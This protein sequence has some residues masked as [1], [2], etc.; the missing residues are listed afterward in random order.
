MPPEVLEKLVARVPAG[1]AAEVAEIARVVA[2]VASPRASYVTGQTL[3]VCGG[4][5]LAQ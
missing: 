4:R 2:F 5:S 1:R 3:F